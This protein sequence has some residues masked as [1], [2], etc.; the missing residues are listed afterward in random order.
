MLRLIVLFFLFFFRFLSGKRKTFAS[1]CITQ[2]GVIISC[3]TTFTVGL[4][5]RQRHRDLTEADGESVCEH[6]SHVSS[7]GLIRPR[8]F[9][10]Q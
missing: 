7:V 5:T 6:E 10:V 3:Y 8:K 1:P 4:A 9:T 2:A